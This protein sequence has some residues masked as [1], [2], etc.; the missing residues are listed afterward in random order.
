MSPEQKWDL[1]EQV[2]QD[3]WH[4]GEC[5]HRYTIP[6][7]WDEPGGSECRLLEPGGKVVASVPPEPEDCP[8]Y[9]KFAA[10]AIEQK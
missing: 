7:R 1:V 5:P 8:G 2:F 3:G 6:G 4:C 10:K 9:E